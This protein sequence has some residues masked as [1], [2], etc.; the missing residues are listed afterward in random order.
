MIKI[1]TENPAETISFGARLGRLL[2]PG[3]VVALCGELG[4]G[5]TT[6][7]KGIA[8]GLGIDEA[9]VL[10]PSFVLIRELRGKKM[11]LFHADFYRLENAK[12]LIGL[13]LDE[14]SF[15]KGVFVMEWAQKAEQFL[16]EDYILIKIS[17]RSKEKREF[18][19][20]LKSR[21]DKYPAL[22]DK[23]EKFKEQFR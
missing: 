19:I 20:Y 22:A 18:R 4:S 11:P 12:Q 6:L 10:S 3:A 23:I 5:K 16:P 7:V 21:N 17:S 2:K 1:I 9:R 14:Y 15:G 13:G 8:Q